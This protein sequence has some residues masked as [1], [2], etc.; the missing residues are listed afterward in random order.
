MPTQHDADPDRSQTLVPCQRSGKCCTHLVGEDGL[1]LTD[2]DIERWDRE[3]RDDILAYVRSVQD[4]ASTSAVTD[5]PV[6]PDGHDLNVCPFLD[7]DLTC[8]IHETKPTVCVRFHCVL[9][10]WPEGG[11]YQVAVARG[12]LDSK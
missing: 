6:D 1:V 7:P 8:S 11:A 12:L 4:P 2:E 10:R 3:G 9:E 5:F